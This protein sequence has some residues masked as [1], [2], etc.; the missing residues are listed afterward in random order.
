MF[1]HIAQAYARP[2]TR[3]FLFTLGYLSSDS[4]IAQTSLDD[5]RART[6]FF[7]SQA[8]AVL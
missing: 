4:A 3:F 1:H 6:P 8:S 7:R 5:L 2:C